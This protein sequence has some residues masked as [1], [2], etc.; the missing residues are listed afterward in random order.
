MQIIHQLA[1]YP[2]ERR[3]AVLALGNFD[4]VHR[5]HQAV[6]GRA[7]RIAQAEARPFGVLTFEPHPV[8]FFKPEVEPFRLTPFRT[9]AHQLQAL[10][11][12]LLVSLP[13]DRTLAGLTAD[14]FIEQVLVQG[15]GV[16]HLVVGYDFCF[17]KGRTGT[18]ETLKQ[19][20]RFTVTV[21]DPS[22]SAS[23]EV[24]S[25]TRIR[26]YLK[27]GEP[28]QA[29]ALLGRPFEIE[30]T[31][32]TGRQLG[33][34]IGFPTA[35]IDLDDYIRPAYG[36]YA[37]RAGV[38]PAEGAPSDWH[39]GV[40]NWGRRP[41]VDGIGEVFEVYLFDFEGD[42]YGCDLRIALI[43]FIRPEEK[44]DGLDA[45]TAQIA[46]DCQAARVILDTRAAGA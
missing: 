26:D 20:G 18:V 19:D 38:S 39:D 27:A 16:G 11:L 14:E 23:G 8:S 46:E 7:G 25:S 6:I 31:V 17:G 13:F 10:G 2:R 21:V 1:D 29:A 41:T 4:G 36:V 32:V 3:G 15:L 9:K 30:G 24:Y 43:E 5:G 37:V 28:G 44:F 34:T 22:G 45:L 12:E 35:N 40:A 33:R 42:L